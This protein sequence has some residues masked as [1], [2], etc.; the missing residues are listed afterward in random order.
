MSEK[1]H[2]LPDWLR[3]KIGK[4]TQGGETRT[5][6]RAHGVCTVCESARCPNVGECF[7]RQTA[8]FMLM[9]DT[10]TRHCRFCAIRHARPSDRLAALDPHEPQRVA[11]TAAHLDLHFV[12]VTSVT[13][14][15]L[16]DGGAGHFVATIEAVRRKLPEAGI[17]V[18]T[19]DFQGDLEAVQMVLDAEPTVFN[20]NVETVR[21]IAPTLRPEADYDRSLQVLAA[22]AKNS[23]QTVV[24][25]GMMVGVGETD[26]QVRALLG[27][28]AET[29]CD[30][31]TIGQYLQPTRR[32]LPVDRYVHPDAFEQYAEWAVEAG[33]QHVAAAPFVRSSYRA[34]SLA[35]AAR[36]SKLTP[37]R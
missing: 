19:P 12:V 36:E 34:D 4:D 33:I 13:R 37:N 10:C 16:S 17:E 23:P 3:I 25:S 31:V 2:R 1:P 8:T 11:E 32:H 35:R 27:D 14:D 15:D 5:L 22:A 7:S 20:H 9:G 29:G 26:E 24:K 28:L 30:V 18:L 6:L 21:Q